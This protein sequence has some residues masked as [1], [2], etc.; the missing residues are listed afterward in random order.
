V[1]AHFADRRHCAKHDAKSDEGDRNDNHAKKHWERTMTDIRAKG[2]HSKSELREHLAELDE[3]APAHHSLE[4]A[5]DADDLN[6]ARKEIA[7]L[8]KEVADIRERLAVIRI[9]TEDVPESRRDA[10]PWRRIAATVIASYVLGK[11]VQRLRLG[12]PGAA[13]APMIVAQLDRRLW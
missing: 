1:A 11:L 12:A 2:F 7:C 3:E 9:Q 4:E 6:A 10:H 8:R 5:S 13:A